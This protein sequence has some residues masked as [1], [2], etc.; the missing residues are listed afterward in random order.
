MTDYKETAKNSGW[1][2]YEEYTPRAMSIPGRTPLK[3]ATDAVRRFWK[4]QMRRSRRRKN[5]EIISNG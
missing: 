2:Q 4:K 5:K 1:A 3:R